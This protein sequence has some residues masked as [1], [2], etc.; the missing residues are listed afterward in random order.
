MLCAYF[1]FIQRQ[2]LGAKDYQVHP[3][4]I[5]PPHP[6]MAVQ[7]VSTVTQCVAEHKLGLLSY[8]MNRMLGNNKPLLGKIKFVG[9]LLVS[10]TKLKAKF[11]T[12]YASTPWCPR[13]VCL[14]LLWLLVV[15]ASGP[16]P[17]GFP[18]IFS[19]GDLRKGLGVFPGWRTK[20]PTCRLER[21]WPRGIGKA[22]ACTSIAGRGSAD[23]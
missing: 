13:L 14:H 7:P 1:S 4:P 23:L 18:R 9:M 8:Q 3:A 10:I 2:R 6:R 11:I 22:W 16:R 12:S 20:G 21:S 15:H 5:A 19:G 17:T